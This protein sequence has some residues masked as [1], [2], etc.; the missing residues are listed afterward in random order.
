MIVRSVSERL[1]SI[2][3]TFFSQARHQCSDAVAPLAN[4]QDCIPTRSLSQQ[5]TE[6]IHQGSMSGVRYAMHRTL[7]GSTTYAWA[8]SQPQGQGGHRTALPH[9]CIRVTRQTSHSIIH[10][11]VMDD[12]LIENFIWALSTS[13]WNMFQTA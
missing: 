5:V 10:H 13:D 11:Y 9:I 8:T 1:R 6:I 12:T 3:R 2:Y 4:A 7:P